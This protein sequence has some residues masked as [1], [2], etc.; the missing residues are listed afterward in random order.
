MLSGWDSYD[1]DYV[2]SGSTPKAAPRSRL[3]V[4]EAYADVS[5]RDSI[6]FRRAH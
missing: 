3:S 4:E 1:V 2:Q 6:Q 5:H